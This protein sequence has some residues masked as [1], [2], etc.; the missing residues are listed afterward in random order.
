MFKTNETVREDNLSEKY[1]KNNK[2]Y[3]TNRKKIITT[4]LRNVTPRRTNKIKE[5]K[6]HTEYKNSYK[7]EQFYGYNKIN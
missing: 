4:P 1:H 6:N 5:I 2:T 3:N 7:P